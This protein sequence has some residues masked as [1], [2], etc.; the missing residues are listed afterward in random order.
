MPL[1]RFLRSAAFQISATL[2][3]I[4]ALTTL[5]V[6]YL[7][8]SREKA[9]FQREILARLHFQAQA[10]ARE[11]T[12]PLLYEDLYRLYALLKNA[13]Q[14]EP[15][16]VGAELFSES[17]GIQIRF[18][19]E[20]RSDP[21]LVVIREEIVS[22]D[23]GRLGEIRLYLRPGAVGQKMRDTEKRLLILVLVIMVNG[24]LAA[25][26]M[27]RRVVRPVLIL[28]RAAQRIGQGGF[29]ET[30]QVK[31]VGEIQELVKNFNQMSLQIRD[32]VEEIR[33]THERM[34]RSEMLAALGQ[35]AAGVAHEIKNPLTS[36]SLLVKLARLGKATPEDFEVLEKE[37]Q[38]ID[39]IVKNFLDFA[40]S[41]KEKLR[42]QRVDP[43][44]ILGEVTELIRPQAK[45]QKVTLVTHFE[46]LAPL[47]T[48]P[49]A[50]KQILL[51]LVLNALEAMPEGGELHLAATLQD[52]HLRLAVRDTGP[53]IPEEVRQR[54]FEPFFTTKPEGTGLGLAIT[55]N[56]VQNLGGEI[57]IRSRE[58]EG[59]EVEISL[60]IKNPE[61]PRG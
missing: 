42:F 40:R 8:L 43:E 29:G 61:G 2:T 12:E 59:T 11:A 1:L 25:L 22:S 58:G 36:I 50:L 32:L 39:R 16:L 53:G 47:E 34:A 10:L 19:R 49:E 4:I 27:A 33:R 9:F 14:S 44:E 3:L 31:A 17:S 56:L 57:E 26:W 54:I 37:I 35:F 21:H 15:D 5:A 52:G 28:S 7:I 6:S 23:I 13:V 55:Y 60:P 24:T 48:S 51:N 20:F 41:G 30:V 46:G 45:K 38:R 18:P